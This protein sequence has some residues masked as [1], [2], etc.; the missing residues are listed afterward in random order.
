[1]KTGAIIVAPQGYRELKS[2]EEYYFLVSSGRL[3]RVRLV[4]FVEASGEIKAEVISMSRLDYESALEDG[5]VHEEIN[6][7]KWPYWLREIAGIS[8][9]YL[10]SNRK[11]NKISYDERV[12]F[13]YLEIAE[14]VIRFDEVLSADDPELEINKYARIHK[15]NPARLRSWF[16]TYVIFGFNKWS[17]MPRLF[18]AGRRGEDKPTGDVKLGRPSRSGKKAGFVVDKEMKERIV[19]GYVAKKSE[20]DSWDTI[21]GEVLIGFFGCKTSIGLK[22]KREFRQP[23]GKPFPSFWQFKYWVG[24]GLPSKALKKDRIGAIASRAK[25]GFKGQFSESLINLYQQVEY[26]GMYF[27]EK[28]SGM[29]ESASAVDG[30]CVVRAACGLSG[31]ILGIGFAEGTEDMEA[32]RMCLFSM[33][34]NKTKFCELFGIS[35]AE[36]EWPSSGLPPNVVFDR[37]P[38]RGYDNASQISWLGVFEM[39]PSYSGQSKAT[40]ES[41][42]P[43]S[44]NI[45]ASPSY[46]HSRL[47]FVEMSK[48]QIFTVLSDNMTSNASRRANDEMY[49]IGFTPTPQNIF[50]YYDCRGRNSAMDIPFSDAVRRFL[51]PRSVKIKRDAV[52]FYGRRYRSEDIVRTEVFDRVAEGVELD[53]TAYVM[54]MCVR[55][56]WLE[57]QGVIYELDAILPSS[58]SSDGLD[59]TLRDLM[60]INARRKLAMA[61]FRDDNPVIQQDMRIRFKENTGKD[62][63]SGKRKAGS[64][65]KDAAVKRA[66]EDY[67]RLMGKKK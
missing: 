10:E 3:N 28:L 44:K 36:G 20:Y 12:N 14:L 16:F 49:E 58:A 50:N 42:H 29:I 15:K 34:I 1:M 8:V 57:Y 60:A 18:N 46:M 67:N 48:R 53:A 39:P 33:A 47:N 31:M 40:V 61:E 55:H 13:R 9:E 43:R 32:Y 41:A 22:G 56:I 52:Y 63:R 62:W 54:T 37:G 65:K 66:E 21:Y 26:D 45:K 24:K 6:N 5:D 4:R 19:Q 2:G 64:P 11:Q 27:E 30:F 38:G 51:T 7:D 59:I 23:E 35:I 25:S 17:L